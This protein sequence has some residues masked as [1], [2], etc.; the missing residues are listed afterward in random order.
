MQKVCF[1]VPG[2][3]PDCC[4]RQRD[5][6]KTAQ[7]IICLKGTFV[8]TTTSLFALLLRFLVCQVLQLCQT[9]NPSPVGLAD[10]PLHVRQGKFDQIFSMVRFL[11]VLGPCSSSSR[12]VF[13]S[14]LFSAWCCSRRGNAKLMWSS[15][16]VSLLLA[17]SCPILSL[18]PRS[19]SPQISAPSDSPQSLLAL[20]RLNS[21]I[22]SA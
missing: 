19:L 3:H 20:H 18:L 10:L 13:T 21:V 5:V 2:T 1:H 12:C 16:E 4:T 6:I 22:T 7:G 15:A 8:S 17:S 9:G 14:S 11:W